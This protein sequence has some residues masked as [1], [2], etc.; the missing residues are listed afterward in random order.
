MYMYLHMCIYTNIFVYIWTRVQY[1]Y[2]SSNFATAI[3]DFLHLHIYIYILLYIYVHITFYI[4]HLYMHI[5]EHL[6]GMLI[7][8]ADQR[9][10]DCYP[11]FPPSKFAVSP[12]DICLSD[13]SQGALLLLDF[14]SKINSFCR[15]CLPSKFAESDD[16]C[17]QGSFQKE[18][19]LQGLFSKRG[20]FCPKCLP[21]K[22]AESDNDYCKGSFQMCPSLQGLFSNRGLFCW[23]Y[24]P[25]KFAES[26]K[27]AI[28]TA[29]T[30]MPVST[31]TYH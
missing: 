28:L 26:R 8:A 24:L 6:Y 18:Q 22:S 30:R 14:S 10:C 7:R 12:H 21:S 5:Y 16:D 3:Q 29:P 9:C 13:F 15:K 1:K 23:R 27:S 20:L 31:Y 19:S 25:S 4:Q 2:V 17:H 11:R